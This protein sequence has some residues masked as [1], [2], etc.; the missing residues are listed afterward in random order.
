MVRGTVL[1]QLKMA[2]KTASWQL[3]AGGSLIRGCKS[4]GKTQILNKQQG[5]AEVHDT[6]QRVLRFL[7]ENGVQGKE[8]MLVITFKGAN[9]QCS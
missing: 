8:Q 6:M 3:A 7:Q 4:T 2:Y 9:Y 5:R 1:N